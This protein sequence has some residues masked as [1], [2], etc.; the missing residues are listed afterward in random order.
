MS[1]SS[2]SSSSSAS[3]NATTATLGNKSRRRG[4]DS[5]G[6][7][8]KEEQV[9]GGKTVSYYMKPEKKRKLEEALLAERVEETSHKTAIIQFQSEDGTLTGDQLQVPFGTTQANLAALVNQLLGNDEALP[10][11][12]FLNELEIDKNLATSVTTQ[13]ASTELVLPVV[14][15]PQSVFRVRAVTR[16]TS[17]IPGHEEA[18]LSVHFSPDGQHLASGSGDCTVRLWDIHTELPLSTLKGHKS[19]VLA[20]AWSPLCQYVASGGMDCEVRVWDATTGKSKGLLRGH[21]KWITALAW[22]PL[23]ARDVGSPV[24]RMASASKDNTVRVWDVVGR[25]GLLSLSGHTAAVKALKWGGCGL[26][27]SASQDRSIK[28][29]NA[30]TGIL[31]RTLDGHAHWVNCLSLNTDFA[32]RVGPYNRKGGA[33]EEGK[34]RHAVCQQKYD[35]VVGR[36][37]TK[38]ELLVSCSDDFTLYLWDPSCSKKPIVRMVGH[39]QPVN[40]VQFSPDGRFI[41]SASFDNSVRLWNGLTGKFVCTLR[42]H[43]QDVYQ[44]CW[45]SDSR[46]LCSSSKDSTMKVWDLRTKKLKSE[47]PGHAD[48]VYAVDW[49]PDGYR[50]VSGGKDCV[51]KIWRA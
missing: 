46:M 2:S 29:W 42:G 12:F 23:V 6:G 51:L 19:W 25:K 18:V 33:P 10:Y 32:L 41:A 30:R 44:L 14:Y 8:S 28:V 22:E 7:D 40:F 48:E 43:V 35:E 20:V 31:V 49:S 3:S 50:L 24:V 47:L 21:K 45:S 5:D 11:S 9:I 16:C 1:S 34:E 37:E 17:T 13:N 4:E 36:T 27:Y 39:Q 15:Q 38:S 26:L